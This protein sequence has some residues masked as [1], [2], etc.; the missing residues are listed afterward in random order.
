MSSTFLSLHYHRQTDFIEDL[1]RPYLPEKGHPLGT[2]HCLRRGEPF[3]HA[4]VSSV[5]TGKLFP[6]PERGFDRM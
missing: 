3:S 5:G 6:S 2:G 4:S 1:K